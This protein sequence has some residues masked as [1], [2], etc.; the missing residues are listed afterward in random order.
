MEIGKWIDYKKRIIEITSIMDAFVI[1][2]EVV[3]N[4]Y[5][6]LHYGKLV[7]INRDLIKED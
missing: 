6:P 4:T 7:V 2:R 3:Y 5:E 1:G